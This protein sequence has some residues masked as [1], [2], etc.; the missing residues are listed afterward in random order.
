MTKKKI[1]EKTG[2]S[3]RRIQFWSESGLLPEIKLETGRGNA[4]NYSDHDV[5]ILQII[6]RLFD[7]GFERRKIKEIVA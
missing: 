4:R 7:I 5:H 6:Q 1:S 2:I 3:E